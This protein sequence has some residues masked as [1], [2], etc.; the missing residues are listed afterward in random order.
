MVIFLISD[1]IRAF[2]SVLQ[3]HENLLT[4]SKPA[5]LLPFTKITSILVQNA[6]LKK[7]LHELQA[8]ITALSEKQVDTHTHTLAPLKAR[9]ISSRFM[10]KCGASKD[11]HVFPHFFCCSVIRLILPWRVSQSVTLGALGTGVGHL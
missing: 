11:K 2:C 3:M 8:K 7:Q 4:T 9:H 10:Q 5:D 1:R 6:D